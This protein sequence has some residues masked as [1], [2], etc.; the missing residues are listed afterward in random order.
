M[1]SNACLGLSLIIPPHS[2]ALE[3]RIEELTLNQTMAGSNSSSSSS[4]TAANTPPMILSTTYS[5][6]NFSST[7]YDLFGSTTDYL[8]KPATSTYP[9]TA[10][11]PLFS[12]SDPLAISSAS[13]F[14][15]TRN[16]HVHPLTRLSLPTPP[17]LLYPSSSQ[18]LIPGW[19]L[20]LPSPHLVTTICQAYFTKIH[21]AT[22]LLNKA[23]F[24]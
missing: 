20:T 3:K 8:T 19:P 2:V 23:K 10:N 21:A 7:E 9:N 16:H 5:V 24:F 13:N 18:L 12:S 14:S 11:V 6:N 15:F 4:S 17:P 1:G 22:D